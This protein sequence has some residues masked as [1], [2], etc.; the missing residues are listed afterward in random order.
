MS[1]VSKVGLKTSSFR[2][3]QVTLVWWPGSSSLSWGVTQLSLCLQSELGLDGAQAVK[4]C[5]IHGKASKQGVCLCLLHSQLSVLGRGACR[6]FVLWVNVVLCT[7]VCG[8][9]CVL[10]GES[11]GSLAPPCCV[12]APCVCTV[13]VAGGVQDLVACHCVCSPVL[14]RGLCPRARCH[15][16]GEETCTTCA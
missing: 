9:A 4:L 2:C 13:L 16:G 15:G 6:W 7:L 11:R 5:H 1:E 14:C 3:S 12:P 10:A 8:M